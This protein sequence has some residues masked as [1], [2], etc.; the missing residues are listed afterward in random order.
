MNRRSNPQVRAAAT[1]GFRDGAVACAGF[2]VLAAIVGYAEPSGITHARDW[3]AAR[4]MGPGE[5]IAAMA[6]VGALFTLIAAFSLTVLRHLG[7]V[8]AS[9]RSGG[10]GRG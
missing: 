7:R 4:P 6:V 8:Y 5:R 10:R 9:P 1:R 2:V 3:L